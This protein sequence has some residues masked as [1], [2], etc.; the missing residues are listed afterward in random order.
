MAQG[1]YVCKTAWMAAFGIGRRMFSNTHQ[2]FMTGQ[3]SF[4][5]ETDRRLTHK[6]S[7]A[8]SWMQMIFNRIGDIMPD[9]LTV[10]LP[11]Y[12]DFKTLYDYMKV[13]LEQQGETPSRIHSFVTSRRLTFTTFVFQRL[14]TKIFFY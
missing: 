9:S 8:R 3:V 4:D 2:S 5:Q 13:D 12:L 1:Y 11:S 7:V 6:S 14:V 10:H